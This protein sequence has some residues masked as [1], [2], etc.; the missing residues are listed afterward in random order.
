MTDRTF[1]HI[2]VPDAFESPLAFLDA[3]SRTSGGFILFIDTEE[4][5]RYA[6]RGF[7]DW[8]GKSP[9]D[10]VGKRLLDLYGPEGYAEFAPQM[11]QA[12]AG[13]AVHYERL[14]RRPDGSPVWISVTLDPYRARD[15]QV[16]GFFSCELEVSEL[17]RTH[18]ALDRALQELASHMENSPLAVIE[19]T[20]AVEVRRWSAQAE[21]IFG[22]KASEVIGRKP[23]T[24]GLVHP[25]S[26]ETTR[27]LTRELIEGAKRNRM[28]TKNI[29]R[30]GRTIHCEWFNSAFFDA[31]GKLSSM[32]S[33]A[34]DVTARVE[35]EEQL[36]QAA[37][38]DSLTGLPNRNSLAARLEHA[39]MRVSRSGDR[40]ALLFIDLDRF[41]KVND[42]HG[43]AAGDEVLR[44]CAARIRTCVREVDT[45]ARLG[46]D[47]FV[48][49]LESDVRPDTPSVIG[50]RIRSAFDV[51]FQWKGTDVRCGASVGVSL[52][53]DHARDPAELLAS[54]DLAMYRFKKVEGQPQ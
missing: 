40:L 16:A 41:K 27:E 9:A 48:V 25:D 20:A 12:L 36:R 43:H 15:G 54:A 37:V 13:N 47:E 31:D 34:Q 39:I 49:L 28:L 14:A 8:F 2:A 32:L 44:Q 52:Y 18:D 30:D 24:F 29:T 26:L 51:P 53:P 17:K 5:V 42:T 6:T 35:S 50:D 11:K 23:S 38:Y 45:V 22:W 19:W 46:G 33:L 3:L 21:A 10:V 7:A 1:S 4:R